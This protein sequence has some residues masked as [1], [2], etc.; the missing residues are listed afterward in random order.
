MALLEARASNGT[1]MVLI[2]KLD[3]LARDLMIQESII[4]DLRKQGFEI[5]SVLEP[6]LCSDDPTRKLMRQMMGAFAEYEKSM[7]VAKLRGARQRTRAGDGRCEGA[8]PYG[9]H[10]GEGAVLAKMRELRTAGVHCAGI[11]ARLNAEG[12]K[13]RRGARWYPMSVGRILRRP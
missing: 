5:V 7:I 4:A 9:H 13:P 3:R 6:D 8:K 1:K 2:E 10:S 12:V 11:A